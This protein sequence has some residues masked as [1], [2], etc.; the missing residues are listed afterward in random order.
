[1]VH[2]NGAHQFVSYKCK[3][4][5][6]KCEHITCANLSEIQLNRLTC[7]FINEMIFKCEFK[8]FVAGTLSLN[9]TY[10]AIIINLDQ[11][12]GLAYIN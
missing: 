11:T 8:V 5:K 6:R 12:Y 3:K 7:D 1:M 4:K 2:Q 10:I 9:N